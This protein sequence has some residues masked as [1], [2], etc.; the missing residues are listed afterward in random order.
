MILELTNLKR[1]LVGNI[2]IPFHPFKQNQIILY[3]L[4]VNIRGMPREGGEDL[5]ADW[6]LS[7]KTGLKFLL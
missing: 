6:I 5:Y 4:C 3:H 2:S 7:S 1:L